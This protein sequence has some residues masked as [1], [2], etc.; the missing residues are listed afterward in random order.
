MIVSLGAAAGELAVNTR[1][2]SSFTHSCDGLAMASV[3]DCM[4]REQ[5]GTIGQS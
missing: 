2:T 1:S 3:L 5:S 4:F